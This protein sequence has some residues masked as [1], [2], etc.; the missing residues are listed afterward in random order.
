M[1]YEIEGS[2]SGTEIKATEYMRIAVV[3]P[4]GVGKSWLAA[5]APDPWF[6]DFDGRINS[7]EGKIISGKS[8]YDNNPLLPDGW[9]KFE[10]DLSKFEQLKQAGKSIPKTFVCDSM[11]SMCQAAMNQ[12]L[13]FGAGNKNVCRKISVGSYSVSVPG[14]FD[15]WEAEYQ[16]V[17][18]S[19][20]RMFAL[21]NVI[22]NFHEAPEEAPESTL[23][24]PLYTG[25]LTVFPVRM[26]KLLPLLNE[27][28]RLSNE[29]GNRVLFTDISDY[30]FNSA[31][32]LR[33]DPQEKPNIKEMFEKHYSRITR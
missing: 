32:T 31:T 22:C 15:A 18:G 24:H 4:S 7:L 26:R 21:G 13:L 33:L 19:I 23:E 6:W 20:S 29:G 14:G 8:Y 11:Q 25:K 3:G 27:K 17:K 5:T 12:T 30:K 16:A 10:Q 1:P 28:W 9:T 2:V